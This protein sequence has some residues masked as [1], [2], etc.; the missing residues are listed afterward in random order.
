MQRVLKSL[1]KLRK[2]VACRSNFA[3]GSRL[4]L[5]C[6]RNIFHL[7]GYLRTLLE[8]T[9]G[10]FLDV[11]CLLCNCMNLCRDSICL[12]GNPE[13]CSLNT[14]EGLLQLAYGFSTGLNSTAAFL[15]RLNSF[16]CICL[17]TTDK[18]R[19]ALC[20]LLRL[21]GELSYLFSDY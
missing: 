10:F 15:H 2:G 14:V 12:L 16:V 8:D 17:N 4:L 3:C 9:R 11:R 20:S 13:S 5:R 21:L 1:S 7:A 6:R 19:D 18:S